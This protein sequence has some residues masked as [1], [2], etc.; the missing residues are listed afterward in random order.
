MAHRFKVWEAS[1]MWGFELRLSESCWESWDGVKCGQLWCVS[2]F[3]SSHLSPLI[4]P[5]SPHH[6]K[7]VSFNNSVVSQEGFWVSTWVAGIN[8]L[9]SGCGRKRYHEVTLTVA[10]RIREEMRFL[11]FQPGHM[12][13]AGVPDASDGGLSHLGAAGRSQALCGWKLSCLRDG[14]ELHVYL[15]TG[16]PVWEISVGE[17]E[18]LTLFSEGFPPLFFRKYFIKE[19]FKSVEKS[20]NFY[21]EP[22]I[23]SPPR[24]QQLIFYYTCSSPPTK[25]SFFLWHISEL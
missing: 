16:N 17:L 2:P 22:P 11:S 8:G 15:S 19:N 20:R 5:L 18:H 13:D 24:L 14:E 21:S 23:Y 4:S 25:Y 6:P 12:G 1:C 10:L 7:L 9:W 3:P